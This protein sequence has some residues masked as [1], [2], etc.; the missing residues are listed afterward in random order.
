MVNSIAFNTQALQ[1]IF[2][3]LNINE[4]KFT[5]IIAYYLLKEKKKV[6]VNT[7]ANRERLS[8]NGFKRTPDRIQRLLDT[9]V[10]KWVLIDEGGNAYSLNERILVS[11]K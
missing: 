11:N 6:F 3:K 5:F 7:P 10:S 2:T 1:I 9:L 8:K 4:V